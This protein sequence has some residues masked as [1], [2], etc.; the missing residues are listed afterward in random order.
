MCN[1]TDKEKH[2]CTRTHIITIKNI[3]KETSYTVY[4][5]NTAHSVNLTCMGLE[6]CQIIRH[7]ILSD[8]TYTDIKFFEV[9]VIAPVL[10]LHN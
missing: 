8:S 2:T 3:L 1:I 5:E 9:I 6:R 7:S 10:G 4:E